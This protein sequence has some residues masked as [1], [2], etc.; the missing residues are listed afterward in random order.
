MEVR[1]NSTTMLIQAIILGED[2]MLL[3]RVRDLMVQQ[4]PAELSRILIEGDHYLFKSI[5]YYLRL[6]RKEPAIHELINSEEFEIAA[7]ERIVFYL[8]Y[9]YRVDELPVEDIFTIQFPFLDQN[10]YLRLLIHGEFVSRDPIISLNILSHLDRKRIDDFLKDYPDPIQFLG[11]LIKKLS[12]DM[13]DAFLY[14]NSELYGY[15]RLFFQNP[16]HSDSEVI[17]ILIEQED[18]VRESLKTLRMAEYFREMKKDAT[19]NHSDHIDA[20]RIYDIVNNLRQMDDV[21]SAIN[22][23]VEKKAF[24]NP[25]EKLIVSNL[26]LNPMYDDLLEAIPEMSHEE[27][28]M[29]G[30]DDLLFF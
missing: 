4:N 9:R 19:G 11:N 24:L 7:L 17:S 20:S 14:K 10:S 22:L 23:M 1:V 30:E 8:H 5:L 28:E 18:K 16:E 25:S 12:G 26:M 15:L 6:F 21:R 13:L 29:F 3:H 2:V 27:L